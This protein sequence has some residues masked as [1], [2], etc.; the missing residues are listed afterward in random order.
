MTN[1]S[2]P[3]LGLISGISQ[4]RLSDE[5]MVHRY[6]DTQDTRYCTSWLYI[7]RA[8]R[9]DLGELGYKVMRGNSMLLM[10][11][12]NDVCYIVN[13]HGPDI[14]D[15][16]QNVCR[17]IKESIGCSIILRKVDEHL[18]KQLLEK[19][20]FEITN[21]LTNPDLL[22]DDAYPEHEIMLA[23]L[24]APDLL[25]HQNAR[26]FARAV[27]RLDKHLAQKQFIQ[28]SSV[29]SYNQA[30]QALTDLAGSNS[31]KFTSY[32]PMLQA[33]FANA[34]PQNRFRLSVYSEGDKVH[35]IYISSSLEEPET[36][37][38]Y[39]ALSSRSLPGI[40]EWMDADF[41]RTAFR[42]GAKKVLLGG[43]ETQGVH[44]YVQKLLVKHP[45][46]RIQTLVYR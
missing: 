24:F 3:Q 11:Y 31:S 6:Y 36:V 45:K 16:L 21:S 4:L 35:G 23:D 2:P 29:V 42:N 17:E 5:D 39:C 37:G 9:L 26:K 12:R 32:Y 38:L 7:L 10:G 34:V 28:D 33:I 30:V 1:S 40:T 14:V 18:T 43:S 15:T 46:Y 25:L 13:P 44:N 27:S 41:L 19:N 20:C 8:T 22:E